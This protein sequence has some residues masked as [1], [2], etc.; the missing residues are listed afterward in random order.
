M[1]ICDPLEND[2]LRHLRYACTVFC[3]SS[4]LSQRQNRRLGRPKRRLSI[5]SDRDNPL[6]EISYLGREGQYQTCMEASCGNVR[7]AKL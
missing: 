1:H 3:Q 2:C 7:D 4:L 6:L 5:L